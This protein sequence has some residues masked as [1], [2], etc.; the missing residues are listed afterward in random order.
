MLMTNSILPSLWPWWQK[1]Q[2]SIHQFSRRRTLAKPSYIMIIKTTPHPTA[3][4]RPEAG[5]SPPPP[6]QPHGA[7]LL[8]PAPWNVLNLGN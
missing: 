6:W 8:I 7:T 3:G 5:H 1:H 4:K 2:I